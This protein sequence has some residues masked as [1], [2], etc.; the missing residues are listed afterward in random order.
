MI[1]GTEF[2]RF[3]RRTRGFSGKSWN[4]ALDAQ[5]MLAAARSGQR[6]GAPSDVIRVYALAARRYWREARALRGAR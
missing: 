5:I 2:Q 6:S 3:T 4:K 1:A